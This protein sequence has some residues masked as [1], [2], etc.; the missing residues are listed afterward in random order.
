MMDKTENIDL[1]GIR[2]ALEMRAEFDPERQVVDV[3]HP[4]VVDLERVHGRSSATSEIE[5]KLGFI[6]TQFER[7]L[8]RA[9]EA[10]RLILRCVEV[11]AAQNV[12]HR[13]ADRRFDHQH[14]RR[15][16]VRRIARSADDLRALISIFLVPIGAQ[17][18]TL[19]AASAA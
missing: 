13:R 5:R 15:F 9:F 10:H 18:A 12:R 2:H 16:R 14:R 8:D 11:A 3:R 4:E 1:L 7:E 17:S 6:L 19:R